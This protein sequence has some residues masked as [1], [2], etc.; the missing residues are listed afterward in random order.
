MRGGAFSFPR[1]ER[2]F[3]EDG[4]ESMF[5]CS[6]DRIRRSMTKRGQAVE[7]L[8]ERRL[9]EGLEERLKVDVGRELG[10]GMGLLGHGRGILS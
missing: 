8:D 4:C 3:G 7:S 5:G 9:S 1:C 10:R 2:R 6:G